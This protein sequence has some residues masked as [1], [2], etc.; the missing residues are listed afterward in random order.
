MVIGSFGPWARALGIVSVSGTDGDGWIVIG[1]G[2]VAAIAL[3]RQAGTRTR[4]PYI[5]AALAG[6]LGIVVTGVDLAELSDKGSADLFGET[7]HLVEPAWGIYVALAGSI[8][9]T[10]LAM[11]ALVRSRAVT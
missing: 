11:L 4:R 5:V 3:V 2:V 10:G 1:A 8:V 6:A 7:L 9:V